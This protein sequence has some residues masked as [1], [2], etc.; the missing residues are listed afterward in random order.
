MIQNLTDTPATTVALAGDWHAQTGHAIAALNALSGASIRTI[1]HLGDFGI[2]DLGPHGYMGRVH[3]TLIQNDQTIFVTL[4]NHENYRLTGRFRLN[5]DGT[6]SY[7]D[8][9]RIRILSRGQHWRWHDTTFTSLGGANSIDRYHRIP[10]KSWFREEQISNSD[11]N[12]AIAHGHADILLTHDVPG[13]VPFYG[14]PEQDSLRV[15]MDW[16][17]DEA[18]YIRGSREQLTRAALGIRPEQIFH[19]HHHTHRTMYV[20]HQD[21]SFTST[22]LHREG[23][24]GNILLLDLITRGSGIFTV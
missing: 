18:L 13:I 23:R 22:C 1:L 4:G 14:T 20:T 9:P 2:F 11:V 8:F 15:Q 24:P 21:Y 3:D 7:S 10:G 17:Y 12:T 16:G 19:G 6:S 5:E